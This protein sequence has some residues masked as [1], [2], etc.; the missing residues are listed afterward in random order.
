[1]NDRQRRRALAL[2]FTL[3]LGLVSLACTPSDQTTSQDLT[4]NSKAC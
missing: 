1:M 2:L 4:A 3:A